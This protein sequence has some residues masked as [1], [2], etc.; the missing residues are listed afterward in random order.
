MIRNWRRFTR[1][2]LALAEAADPTARAGRGH[3][4]RRHAG[5]ARCRALRHGSSNAARPAARTRWIRHQGRAPPCT[6]GCDSPSTSAPRTSC[7]GRFRAI[8]APDAVAALNRL[9][10]AATAAGLTDGVPKRKLFLIRNPDWSKGAQTQTEL[11]AFRAAGGVD[12]GLGNRDIRAL[13]ALQ[14]LLAE[15]PQQSA[16]LAAWPA[17]RRATSRSSG[18]RSARHDGPD[19]GTDRV[20]GPNGG[21]P[22]RRPH[23]GTRTVDGARTCRG[24]RPRRRPERLAPAGTAH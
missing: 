12:L 16:R 5:A 7:T 13:I 21:S 22:R 14:T 11:K 1:A 19:A 8:A 24:R 10:K 6:P 3:R 15:A 4:G 2:S 18:E 17:A 9:R 20:T 23:D